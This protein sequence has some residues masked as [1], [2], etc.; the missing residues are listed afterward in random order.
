MA[1]NSGGGKG[2]YLIIGGLVVAVA[3]MAFFLFA[4]SN[5]PDLAI[6]IGDSGITVDTN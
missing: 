5:E 3:V 1:N 6:D 4:P 2:L